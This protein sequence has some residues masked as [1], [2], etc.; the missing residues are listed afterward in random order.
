MSI[1]EML[2]KIMSNKNTDSKTTEKESS[3]TVMSSESTEEKV[4]KYYREREV[5]RN[6]DEDG[7]VVASKLFQCIWGQI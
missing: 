7:L 3:C 4:K 6:T 5:I 2:R 1:Y